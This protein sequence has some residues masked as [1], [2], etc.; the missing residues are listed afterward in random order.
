MRGDLRRPATSKPLGFSGRV[1][2]SASQ[3]GALV[4]GRRGSSLV[5]AAPDPASPTHQRSNCSI[6]CRDERP[7]GAPVKALAGVEERA[8]ASHSSEEERRHD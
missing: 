8:T 5:Q 2:L 3:L 6:S 1:A 4:G 7:G